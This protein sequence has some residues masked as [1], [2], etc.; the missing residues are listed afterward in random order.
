MKIIVAP[1]SF[2]GSLTSAQVI[3]GIEIAAKKHFPDCE[4]VKLPIADGGEGTVDALAGAVGGE[5][6]Y[7]MVRGPLGNL[8]NAKYGIIHGDTAVVEM[9]AA[10]GLPL[11]PLQ[12]KN[13][14]LATSYGTGQIIR[15]VVEDGY[16]KIIIAV[17]GSATNDGGIGAMTAL[18]MEFLD[19]DGRVLEPIG[20]NLAAIAD[21]HMENL[22]PGLSEAEITIMCDVDN[23]LLGPHGATYVY[24]P[25]KGGTKESLDILEAGMKNY[26]DI[27]E[28]KS[29]VSFHDLPGAG[30][31]G[32]ISTALTA[33]AGAKLGSGISVVLEAIEF[34]ENL[35][36]TDLVITGEGRLDVQ[37]VR[38]KVVYGIGVA[39]KRHGIP[40]IALVGGM[41]E[42]AEA[43]YEFGVG[44]VMVTVNGIMSLEEAMG[45]AKELLGSAADRMFRLI[46]I[47][48]AL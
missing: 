21:Y 6:R 30:A 40:V 19:R 10:S 11:V 5:F 35:K 25:Q 22:C 17:G 14:L 9:A 36:N 13:I 42:G 24:G 34:E 47:G 15:K 32:G 18:G 29:G 7:I 39:C 20:K 3:E 28:H 8:V 12:E 26:A 38:G 48:K 2:K 27:I 23:P 41:A 44:S 45:E 46:K 4:I 16:R 31:A 43:I 37:S 33:F 1:D